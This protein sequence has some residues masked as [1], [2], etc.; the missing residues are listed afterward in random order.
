LKEQKGEEDHL[1]IQLFRNFRSRQ[2]ILDITNFVFEVIM[3]KN[4]GS[5]DYNEQEYLNYG[6]NYPAPEGNHTLAETTQILLIDL[7]QEESIT[8]FQDENENKM[9]EDNLLEEEE[10][11][12]VEDEV[13]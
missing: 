11:E 7:K 4:L 1:K 3:S 9:Q 12:R 5:I 6:A 8:A 13:L 10:E 2:N